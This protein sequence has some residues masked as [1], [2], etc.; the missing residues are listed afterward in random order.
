MRIWPGHHAPLGATFDGIGHELLGV[1]RARRARRAVP[2]RR[3]G[4]GNPR[5]P[6]RA[7]GALLARLPAGREA[8]PALW[9]QGARTVGPGA[10]AVVQPRQAAARSLRQG[11]RRPVELERS[12]LSR[13]TS[14]RRSPRATISTALPSCPRASSSTRSSTG[15]RTAGRRR[16][17]TAPS[18]TRRTSRASPAR[19]RTF[20]TSCAARMPGM[21]HPEAIKY[22]QRLGVTAVELLPV[23][24]FVQDSTPA[25]SRPAQLLGLQLDRLPR[26]AQRV[27]AAASAASRCRSSSI[28]SRRCT[29]RGSR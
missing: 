4:C 22:L 28:S 13:I 25:R 10:G 17:G 2:V 26:A 3:P 19:I 23:H 9:I 12:R 29:R 8:G 6:D 16:R 24:Q 18:S 11:D 1:F 20:P 5:R 14:P 15:A 7:D 21:A 27:R